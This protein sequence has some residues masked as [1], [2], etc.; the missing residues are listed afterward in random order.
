M[1]H[2]K[3]G[4]STSLGRDS[5]GQRLGVKVADGQTTN[6]GQILVRQRGTKIHPGKNVKIG[7]DDTLYASVAGIVK[8]TQKMKANFHGALK[9]RVFA[10]VE[11]SK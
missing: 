5:H 11:K 9:H 7:G 3:A 8:F 10:N 4:G 1:A 6:A 2:K